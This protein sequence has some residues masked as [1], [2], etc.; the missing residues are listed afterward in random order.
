MSAA[1]YQPRGGVSL[2][3]AD[4][5]A[6]VTIQR[7][8]RF[9][10]LS[11]ETLT[12]LRDVARALRTGTTAWRADAAGGLTAGERAAGMPLAAWW[13]NDDGGVLSAGRRNFHQSTAAIAT[14]TGIKSSKT[15][16]GWTLC[17]RTSCLC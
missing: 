16:T 5:I 12:G 3:V 14:A 17:E 7:G 13:G 10:A 2:A 1:D 6:R 15:D 9:N 11:Q 8:D 4:G